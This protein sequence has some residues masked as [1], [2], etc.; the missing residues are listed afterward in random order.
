MRNSSFLFGLANYL[1]L[2]S[3]YENTYMHLYNE[4]KFNID[5][6]SYHSTFVSMQDVAPTGDAEKQLLTQKLAFGVALAR[7]L[8]K[9]NVLS[10]KELLPA[11]VLNPGTLLVISSQPYEK[12]VV[13]HL[14]SCCKYHLQRIHICICTIFYLLSCYG[15]HAFPLMPRYI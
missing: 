3:D 7:L 13:S 14:R 2:K 5:F 8:V 4:M 11:H 12:I 10:A 15:F 1:G 6:V 9:N